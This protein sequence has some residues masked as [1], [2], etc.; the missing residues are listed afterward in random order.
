MKT[1]IIVSMVLA[2]G[3]IMALSLPAAAWTTGATPGSGITNTPH[4][5]RATATANGMKI[6]GLDEICVV[7]H[8]PHNADAAA[9]PLWNH[10]LTTQTFTV[11]TSPTLDAS[12][13]QPTGISKMCLSCHDGVTAIDAYGGAAGS[14]PMTVGNGA[15]DMHII[16]VDLS[17]DHPV[18]FDYAAAQATDTELVAATGDD[19]GGKQML[20]GG[21]LHCASCHDPHN[22]DVATGG[23]DTSDPHF[24]RIARAGSAICLTCHSK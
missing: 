14:L 12:V 11:Y 1:N 22:K 13:G 15:E 24:L 18:S 6:P 3:L 19:I 23:E 2:V 4:D 8:T 21:E 17:N 5:M 20:F 10:T 16:G 9:K 7:C